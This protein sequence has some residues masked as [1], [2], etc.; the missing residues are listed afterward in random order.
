MMSNLKSEISTRPPQNMMPISFFYQ[1][2][3]VIGDPILLGGLKMG[4]E[5]VDQSGTSWERRGWRI[6]LGCKP[7]MMSR[8]TD[9][10]S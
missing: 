4:D 7:L 5:V 3:L 10:T 1:I 9:D 8:V 2:L 6:Y